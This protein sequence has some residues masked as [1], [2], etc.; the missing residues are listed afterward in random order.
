MRAVVASFV[1]T[2]CLA[3][4]V[5]AFG[6]DSQAATGK[7]A[8]AACS[9]LTREL[10]LQV[11]PYEQ[12][13]PAVRDMHRQLLAQLPPRE[14]PVGAAGSAC[15][16]GPIHMQIDPF[17][18]PANVEKSLAK[19]AAPLSGLGDVAFFHDNRGRFAELYVRAGARVLTIQ[20]DV[21]DGRTPES[22]K[23]NAIA[24]AEALLPKLR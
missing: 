4:H 10:V 6:A 21:P 23:P 2:G 7:Q 17:A 20:M 16:Y 22:V 8:T 9:L 15:D 19:T 24:L 13:P 18:S 12:Q 11:S 5:P 14:E 1:L 3:I